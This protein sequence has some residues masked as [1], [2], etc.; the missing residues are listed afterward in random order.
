MSNSTKFTAGRFLVA[1]CFAVCLITFGTVGPANEAHADGGA[2]D[3]IT[4]WDSLGPLGIQDSIPVGLDDPT[5]PSSS[6]FEDLIECAMQL[7]L[8]LIP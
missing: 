2:L 4:R 1:L 5:D 3:T 8:S 6:V 7:A